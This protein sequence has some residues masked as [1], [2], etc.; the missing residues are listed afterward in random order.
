MRSDRKEWTIIPSCW[1]GGGED[2]RLCIQRG[3]FWLNDGFGFPPWFWIIAYYH[4]LHAG[5]NKELCFIWFSFNV[6]T[7]GQWLESQLTKQSSDLQFAWVYGFAC[8]PVCFLISYS[9]F[10]QQSKDLHI[11]LRGNSSLS[12]CLSVCPGLPCHWWQCIQDEPSI[13]ATETGI[14]AMG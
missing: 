7:T 10:L 3:I 8:S 9:G 1:E 11:R 13:A 14:P 12:L 2:S 6:R 5:G 4:C